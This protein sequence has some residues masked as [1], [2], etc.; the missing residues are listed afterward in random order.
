M[1]SLRS[2][3]PALRLSRVATAFFKTARLTEQR[4][5]QYKLEQRKQQYKLET[6]LD[7][8]F[9]VEKINTTVRRQTKRQ[10]KRQTE[11][12][13]GTEVDQEDCPVH[14]SFA[15]FFLLSSAESE[16]DIF[17][18]SFNLDICACRAQ[19]RNKQ[20]CEISQI[21]IDFV[22]YLGI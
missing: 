15:Y 21:T 4:K 11:S 16:E 17:L 20:V 14:F 10:T 8:L 7:V 3:R 22:Y 18:L 1:A 2:G 19:T 9:G 5:Q 6:N 13:R 12:Q